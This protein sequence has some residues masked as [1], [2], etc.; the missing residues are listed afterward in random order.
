MNGNS[1]GEP[2]VQAPEE[3]ERRIW[4]QVEEG[5]DEERLL[6]SREK[7]ARDLAKKLDREL[8]RNGWRIFV[9]GIAHSLATG[10]APQRRNAEVALVTQ[11]RR[12]RDQ[13]QE[14]LPDRLD[15]LKR[16]VAAGLARPEPTP[17][18]DE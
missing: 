17:K 14:L 16:I 4:R 12:W 7:R 6:P 18:R 9:S 8:D 11:V 3:L 10:K 15:D 1:M 5:L 13:V 2:E